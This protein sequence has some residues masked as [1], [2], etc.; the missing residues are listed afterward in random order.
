MELPRSSGVL[1][2]PTSLPG[3]RLG[4]EAYR[5]VDW[6]AAAGQSVVADAAARPA[7]RVRAR[8]TRRRPRSRAGAA[9]SPSRARASRRARSSALPSRGTAYWIGD[10]AAFAGDGA[11]ADQVRFEREWSALREYA[12][13]AR[14]AADRR[15]ADLRRRGRRRPRRAP[16]ALPGTASSPA[17]RRTTSAATGQLWG[18]P[19]YD[20]HAIGGRRLP[21][22]DRALPAH[23]RA[24]RPD[25]DRPLPRLRRLLGGARRRARRARR[26]PLAAR[27][28]ARA[29]RGGASASSAS[30]R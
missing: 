24:R 10:W 27:A 26:R 13:R 4:A 8:R 7:R 15:P 3:G 30:C 23:V 12:A 21:L 16:R 22:V 9:C 20:W 19:L 17:C 5:F 11:L 25:A 14:R 29:L 6:L 18:N 28:R 2:H 1:L